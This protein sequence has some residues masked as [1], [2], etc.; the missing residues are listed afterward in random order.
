MGA[1]MS[2]TYSGELKNPTRTLHTE[3]RVQPHSKTFTFTQRMCKSVGEEQTLRTV[4]RLTGH[5][6]HVVTDS[7]DPV[8]G[9]VIKGNPTMI[10][11]P[12]RGVCDVEWGTEYYQCKRIKLQRQD[13]YDESVA[14]RGK[15]SKSVAPLSAPAATAPAPHPPQLVLPTPQSQQ[16]AFSFNA[17]VP[18]SPR[19]Q[20][21]ADKVSDVNTKTPKTCDV[22]I[23]F[24]PFALPTTAL[25]MMHYKSP[26]H[27]KA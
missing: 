27:S 26:P 13:I 10:A 1:S 15:F 24:I 25:I 22:A 3:L 11:R 21:A 14:R 20:H 2:Q 18:R 4:L 23:P 12:E 7:I 9:R 8:S 6:S 5:I 16:R 17:P 19:S